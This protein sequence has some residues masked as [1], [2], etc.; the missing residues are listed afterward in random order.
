MKNTILIPVSILLAVT[1]LKGQDTLVFSGTVLITKE[2]YKTKVLIFEDGVRIS[3][4]GA[5]KIKIECEKSFVGNRCQIL[6]D[7]RDGNPGRDGRSGIEGDRAR[8]A[9]ESGG[10]GGAGESGGYGTNLEIDFGIIQQLGSIYID[11]HGGKGGRGGNGGRGG[12]GGDA[13]CSDRGGQGARGGDA[14]TGG[15]GGNG[16][17]VTIKYCFS[18][19]IIPIFKQTDKNSGLISVNYSGGAS[20]GAG[21]PGSGGKGGASKDGCGVKYFEYCII[22]AKV[23]TK[24]RSK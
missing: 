9:T 24:I 18:K 10:I 13:D 21:N 15:K 16:G 3:T 4:S 19:G 17:I 2:F 1:F 12:K 23:N 5:N 22:P 7:G 11:V 14:G 8:D 6:G 20:D